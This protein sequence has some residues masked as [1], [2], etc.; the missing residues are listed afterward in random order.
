MEQQEVEHLQ[1]PSEGVSSRRQCAVCFG[2][3]PHILHLLPYRG[4]H[5]HLYTTCVLAAHSGSL[6]PIIFHVFLHNPPPPS[7]CLL[8]CKC[9]SI[10]LMPPILILISLSSTSLPNTNVIEIYLHLAKQLVVA[11]SLAFES[12][13]SVAVMAR[14]NAEIRVKEAL[15]AKA[16]E[17]RVHDGATGCSSQSSDADDWYL[18]C[19]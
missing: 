7:L 4:L 18:W 13:I 9:P 2:T 17:N 10:L 5:R 19:S 15:M 14:V 6:C 1:Q 12:I 11:S 16:G 3:H 8:Y